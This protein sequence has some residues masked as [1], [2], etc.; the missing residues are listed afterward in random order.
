VQLFTD[1]L[2]RLLKYVEFMKKVVP[3][4]DDLFDFFY[5][6]LPGYEEVGRRRVLLGCWGSFQNPAVCDFQYQTM[7][8]WGRAMFV[9]PG[10][11][12]DGELVTTDLVTINLGMR[13]LLGSSF[14]DDWQEG[15]IKA[16]GHSVK[17]NLPK[18]VSLPE[19][20]FEWRIPK[21]ANTIERNRAR[22]YFQAYAAAT[23]LHFVEQA[24]KEV[25]AGRLKTWTE[26]RVP[27]EAIGGARH[28]VAPHGHP[29]WSHRQ[30]PSLSAH[31]VE[32]QPPRSIRNSGSL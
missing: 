7:P 29:Q 12:V 26:F 6:A 22:T 4:H 19:T 3:L 5:D 10:V 1:Y 11:I 27:E 31:A 20:Q 14:Y 16:T 21:W 25:H 2:V 30:L 18:T 13:I 24:L 32:R 9:T 23:A 8:D 17:I 15:Y 28:P